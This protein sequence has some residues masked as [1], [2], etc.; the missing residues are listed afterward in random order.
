[1]SSVDGRAVAPFYCVVVR[2]SRR[3]RRVWGWGS[4]FL[5]V[6]ATPA[7]GT[8]KPGAKP[9]GVKVTIES[10]DPDIVLEGQAT[11]GQG[12]APA[13][14]DGTAD[15]GAGAAD[16]AE[17]PLPLEDGRWEVMCAPPCQRRVPREALFLI[18]GTG[19]TTSAVFSLPAKASS[20]SLDVKTGTARWYWTGAIAAIAGATFVIGSVVP[21][22][23]LGGSFSTGEKVMA[24]AGLVLMGGGAPLWWFNRTTVVF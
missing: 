9:R 22:L 16:A 6:L 15:E 20:V 5:L 11:G 18:T 13:G 21:R 7:V 24:G 4:F 12:G 2:L 14:T 3:S 10:T 23:A 8:A 1:M 17:V 19:V